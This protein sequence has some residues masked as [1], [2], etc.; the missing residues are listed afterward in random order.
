MTIL[1]IYCDVTPL[2]AMRVD[3]SG[4]D[5]H[6]WTSDGA[7]ITEILI[8]DS[9]KVEALRDALTEWLERRQ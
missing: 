3:T 6:I 4:E 1:N 7:D 9:A 5:V 8:S 2:D